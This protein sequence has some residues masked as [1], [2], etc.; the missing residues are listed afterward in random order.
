MYQMGRGKYEVAIEALKQA[1]RL[2]A[3]SDYAI[4][5]QFQMAQ[6]CEH[7][8]KLADALAAL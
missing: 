3:G 6:R 1:L 5:A 8:D 7:Q 2:H 4:E